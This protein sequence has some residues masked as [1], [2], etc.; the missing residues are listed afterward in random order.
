MCGMLS[1]PDVLQC[2]EEDWDVSGVASSSRTCG[3][4][5]K[6]NK[7]QKLFTFEFGGQNFII[8][9]RLE[10]H[11]RIYVKTFGKHVDVGLEFFICFHAYIKK[12]IS[13]KEI[14]SL[15]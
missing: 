4:G 5:L 15:T 1:F 10:A 8:S 13:L 2:S 6:Y 3:A 12:H 7:Q 14:F 9:K 11:C